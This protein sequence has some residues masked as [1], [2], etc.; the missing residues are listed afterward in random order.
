MRPAR[1]LFSAALL[2]IAVMLAARAGRA[3]RTLTL[4]EA[5]TVADRQRAE[6][7]QADLE[8]E[9]ARLQRLEAKLAWFDFRVG[10]EAQAGVSGGYLGFSPGAVGAESALAIGNTPV[11]SSVAG[12]YQFE[13]DGSLNVPVFSGLRL[14]STLSAANWHHRASEQRM[15]LTELE[16]MVEAA[17]AYWAVRR[18]ELLREAVQAELTR[19]NELEQLTQRELAVGVVPAFDLNRVRAQRLA[20]EARLRAADR[21]VVEARAQLGAAL[22]LDESVRLVDDPR[23]YRPTVVPLADAEKAALA[24][25]PALQAARADFQGSAATVRA[26]KGGYWPELDLVAAAG[27]G[28]GQPPPEL[29][30]PPSLWGG[31]FA[32]ARVRWPLFD[33]LQTW[34]KVREA[35]L[36][37]DQADVERARQRARVLA[38]V[39][40]AH[41]ELTSAMAE[42]RSIAQ[43]V[44]LGRANVELAR[45]RYLAGT[46]RLF[47][48]LDVQRELT[49]LEQEWIDHAVAVA[50]GDARLRAAMG[51]K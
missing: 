15:K 43:A 49:E 13:V 11:Q 9:R 7:T 21:I 39:R 48:V 18:G 34:T 6:L 20:V 45:K 1:R 14:E 3:E 51:K 8:V 30:A 32:G 37:R 23:S 44:E 22:Q 17:R 41:A 26:A 29:A 40:T 46:S 4:A 36:T 24:A 12:I 35:A 19:D 38:E 31:F 28:G 50:E 47:E 16:V 42:M 10:A 27:V 33:M 5:L 25:H 2:G